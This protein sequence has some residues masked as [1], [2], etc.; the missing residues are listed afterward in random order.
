MAQNS[1]KR[2]QDG[3]KEAQDGPTMAQDGPKMAPDSPKIALYSTYNDSATIHFTIFFV[4]ASIAGNGNYL[5]FNVLNA[6][7]NNTRMMAVICGKLIQ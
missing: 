6:I 1:P 5:T 4:P 3:P 7:I 2:A